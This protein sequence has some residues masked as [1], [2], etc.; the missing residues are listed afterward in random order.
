MKNTI[1]QE[2]QSVRSECEYI[3]RSLENQLGDVYRKIDKIEKQIQE[4][5]NK[6]T[7]D[8]IIYTE[9]APISE[10]VKEK[11]ADPIQEPVHTVQEPTQEE[12][13]KEIEK[14]V[15]DN[16]IH[17]EPVAKKVEQKTA[18]DFKEVSQEKKTVQK[19]IIAKKAEQKT[20]KKA[21]KKVKKKTKKSEPSL[22]VNN[23]VVETIVGLIVP[24]FREISS[25]FVKSYQHYKNENKL[26]VFFMTLTG[27]VTLLF[28][29]GFLAQYS[30]VN[31][32]DMLNAWGKLATGLTITTAVILGGIRLIS[33]STKFTEFGSSLLGLS[34]IINYLFIYYLCDANDGFTALQ[35][36]LLIVCNSAIGAILALRFETKV[37]AVLSLLGGAFV[38]FFL[39]SLQGGTELYFYFSFLFL[40][41]IS[42]IYIGQKI[43][44]DTLVKL[45]FFVSIGMI[46]YLVFSGSDF[47]NTFVYLIIFHAFAYLFFFVSVRDVQNFAI[48]ART[49]VMVVTNTIALIANIY[50]LFTQFE[51]KY[52]AMGITFL[53]NALI[54][55]GFLASQYSKL[56]KGLKVISFALIGTFSAIAVPALLGHHLMGIAWGLEACLLLFFGFKF[57]FKEIRKE[58]Y[59]L[60]IVSLGKIIWSSR[61]LYEIINESL[62]NTIFWNFTS[63]GIVLSAILGIA[64]IYR[65]QIEGRENFVVNKL[66]ELFAIWSSLFLGVVGY[67]FI[68]KWILVIMPLYFLGVLYFSN[69]KYRLSFADFWALVGLFALPMIAYGL[70]AYDEKSLRFSSQLAFAKVGLVE[71]LALLWGLEWYFAKL[72]GKRFYVFVSKALRVLFYLLVPVLTVY[73]GYKYLPE[74]TL[75]FLWLSAMISFG[76]FEFVKRAILAVAFYIWIFATTAVTFTTIID[77]STVNF[78]YSFTFIDFLPLLLGF[79]SLGFVYF[80]KKGYTEKKSILNLVFRYWFHYIAGTLGIIMVALNVEEIIISSLLVSYYLVLIAFS[81]KINFLGKAKKLTHRLAFFVFIFS[82]CIIVDTHLSSGEQVLWGLL[83]LVNLVGF[84]AFVY[85][86]NL[87]YTK[88]N[89]IWKLD[90]YLVHILCTTLYSLVISNFNGEGFFLTICLMI[91]TI[92][93]LLTSLKTYKVLKGGYISLFVITLGKLFIFDLASFS[94]VQKVIVFMAIGLLLLGASFLFL[95]YKKDDEKEG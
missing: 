56:S 37:V 72:E 6:A 13:R 40:L 84:G 43:K 86:E 46:G 45:S 74:Y 49:I 83:N 77:H 63:F 44:W 8:E 73:P 48:N 62:I 51:V 20:V 39:P 32:I 91:H 17:T 92:V 60:L 64:Y 12:I 31:Y 71:V 18:I 9:P 22:L 65:S 11:K 35:G 87:F 67:A 27:I 21:K 23:F 79:V 4:T 89:A 59:L 1:E 80:F 93:I 28:G 5:V 61:Y 33:K 26:P 54:I 85:K 52:T 68:G 41:A 50:V 95:K 81:Q 42:A 94:L 7:H 16:T 29:F 3:K 19:V 66:A 36:F 15:L 88:R 30:A 82:V 76:V 90:I 24:P 58:G 78:N 14:F 55:I 70:S 34:I 10:V 25:F 38:P 2:I 53:A 57:Q 47:S 69:K 75:S